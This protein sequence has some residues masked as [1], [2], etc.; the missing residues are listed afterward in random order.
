ME[1]S[2]A[3][4]KKKSELKGFIVGNHFPPLII[5]C[6]NLQRLIQHFNAK[7]KIEKDEDGEEKFV[8]LIPEE[9]FKPTGKTIHVVPNVGTR[10]LLQLEEGPLKITTY[11]GSGKGKLELYPISVLYIP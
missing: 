8:L 9:K 4:C 1:E 3:L 10:E 7:V 11:K 5:V 6:E 2:C